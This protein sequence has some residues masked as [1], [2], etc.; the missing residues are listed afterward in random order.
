MSR[1]VLLVLFLV[2][3]AVAAVLVASGRAS[4]VKPSA[5]PAQVISWQAAAPSPGAQAA[6]AVPVS[7]PAPVAPAPRVL[8]TAAPDRYD[9]AL[10]GTQACLLVRENGKDVVS[11]SPDAPLA[12]A[13]TQKIVLAAAAL[14]DLGGGFRYTTSAVAPAKPHNGTV[15]DLWLVGGGDPVLFTADYNGWLHAQNRYRDVP[16]TSLEA[17]A[18]RIAASGVKRI[19]GGVHPDE[20]H[21]DN[22]RSLA[23]WKPGYVTDGETGALGAL[24]TDEGYDA[25]KPKLVLAANPAVS[26]ANRLADLL[27]ARGVAVGGARDPGA[28]PA[29]GSEVASV[30]SPPLSAILTGMLRSSDNTTAE[31]VLRE[32]GRHRGDP[33]T[34][35][36]LQ[37][38]EAAMHELHVPMDGVTMLDG[39]GLSAGN[40]STCRTLVGAIDAA[41]IMPMLAPAGSGTLVHRVKY[42]SLRAKT[43]SIDGVSSIAGAVGRREFALVMNGVPNYNA[44]IALQDRVLALLAAS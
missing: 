12:P 14:H 3:Q 43:G 38:V 5:S 41:P 36:G 1:K 30:S 10:G 22:T 13:S 28:A 39:S 32:V 35:G 16:V 15:G 44:G 17:L 27:A 19:S 6:A 34:A 42:P 33:T 20:S 8:P 40:R 29:G 7:A 37:A 21:F 4:A 23:S 26:A 25:W 2:A 9:A 11:R 18:D 24:V 31:L